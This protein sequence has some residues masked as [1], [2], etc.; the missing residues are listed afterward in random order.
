MQVFSAVTGAITHLTFPI[1]DQFNAS[2]ALGSV[3][4]ATEWGLENNANIPE[5]DIKVDSIAVT[6]VTKKLKA[7]WTPELGQDLN[8]YHNLDAEVEL[9]SILSEQ[10]ALEIDREIIS[11]LVRGA[12]AA[13]YYWSRAPGLFV[14]RTTGTEIGASSAAPDFTGTVSEWYETLV[15]TINDVS[16]QIHR[17]TLRGGANFVVCGPEVAGHHR[18]GPPKVDK[19]RPPHPT[20]TRHN[21][22]PPK[23]KNNPPNTPPQPHPQPP[24]PT[25][26]HPKK[27]T[28]H[29]TKKKPPKKKQQTTH[30]T[31]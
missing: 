8:A 14:D 19:S 18:A 30:T 31:P 16:A 13:T 11:D 5:I 1:D 2:N 12:T 29:N 6:A 9:T 24:K 10:I 25:T 27:I 23:N 15:E 26:T 7:K 22:D 4:G 21:Q 3:I 17:K 20:H 28:T